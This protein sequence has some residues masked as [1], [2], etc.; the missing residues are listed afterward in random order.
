LLLRRYERWR[1]GK[2]KEEEEEE[3]EEGGKGQ[4]KDLELSSF[5]LHMSDE[6]DEKT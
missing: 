3:E 1:W 6:R 2:K 5:R 4:Q